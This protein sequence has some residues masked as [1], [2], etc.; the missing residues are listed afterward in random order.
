[1]VQDTQQHH[2]TFDN[3]Q[4]HQTA[5]INA[6]SNVFKAG[7][8]AKRNTDGAAECVNPF[9][10]I[11]SES[12]H[13]VV[14][15]LQHS[16]EIPRAKRRKIQ[17]NIL[18]IEMETG[19]GKTYTFVRAMFK[20]N[21]QFGVCKFVLLVPTLAIKSAIISFIE[22]ASA[23]SHFHA[24][25]NQKIQLNVINA[26]DKPN[27]TNPLEASSL[28]LAVKQFVEAKSSPQS[29][30]Q[31]LLL[32][33]GMLNSPTFQDK[34]SVSILGD[35]IATPFEAIQAVKPFLII[36]EPHRFPLRKKTWRNI[37]RLRPQSILR[38][39]ATFNDT[40]AHLIYS[41]DAAKSFALGLV[42]AV[43]NWPFSKLNDFSTKLKLVSIH[44]ANPNFNPVRPPI[45]EILID[46]GLDERIDSFAV[47]HLFEN[48]ERS[49][50]R[51]KLYD[52]ILTGL[53]ANSLTIEEIEEKWIRLSNGLF[54]NIGQSIDPL[55]DNIN[56]T[57]ED[58][59]IQKVI[60]L[61]FDL[62][63]ELMTRSPR[64][65]PFTLFF[66]SNID[67]YRDESLNRKDFSNFE[68]RS[69]R[70]KIETWV[71]NEARRRL[72]TETDTFYKEYLTL[73]IENPRLVHGGY[74]ARD[75]TSKN[76]L[77]F[78]QKEEILHNKHDLLALN[79]PRR[80]IF[81]KWALKEGWDNP[82]VFQVCKLRASGSL[83]GHIQ[84]LGRGLRLPV[85][86]RLQRVRDSSLILRYFTDEME[87]P[88]LVHDESLIT[89]TIRGAR[90]DE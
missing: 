86:E 19:T 72:K 75:N 48:G 18:D 23:R 7:E 90:D 35:A 50:H 10:E 47:F 36:D 12:L 80:F 29:P 8:F 59:M 32:N 26:G 73:T 20:L 69:L 42:K 4:R 88:P 41:L 60:E 53:S 78:E 16:N 37:V 40:Y 56:Q 54:L 39:G 25:F 43:E 46:S 57:I 27:K 14:R 17:Q 9:F 87:E 61:H 82:N 65:K 24:D 81:T 70:E 64:I 83:S 89:K 45:G 2:Q 51:V 67:D 77:H 63:Q 1:M 58:E 49:R 22:S 79:N 5:A 84:E 55:S 6:I 15:Q 38:F 28:P 85:D 74:F 68:H 3:G 34:Y 33:A 52:D 71:N 62:E 44:I 21:Q 31:V 13:A 66:I 11:T 76:G 30:I